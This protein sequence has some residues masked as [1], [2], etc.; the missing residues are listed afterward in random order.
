MIPAAFRL[1]AR[2]WFIAGLIAA[3]WLA[4]RS[5]APPAPSVPSHVAR[6]ETVHVRA[7]AQTD[8][9]RADVTRWVTRWRTDT[10]RDTDTLTV[11]DTLYRIVNAAAF[12]S[13]VRACQ[14][15]SDAVLVERSACA[16]AKRVRDDSIRVLQPRFRDRF[17]VTVGY[18]LTATPGGTFH[19]GA[20][21]GVG[22]RVW[23]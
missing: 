1:S 18:G 2:G 22:I 15:L 13:T 5:C 6:A 7:M 10:I 14:L 8:T 21:V 23:P 3:A 17:G 20:Q 16:E 9:V 4:G 19:H 11:R 12:D